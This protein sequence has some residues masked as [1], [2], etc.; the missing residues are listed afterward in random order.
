M[1]DFLH[2][3]DF[4]YTLY[5][6]FELIKIWSPRGDSLCSRKPCFKVNPS[7]YH[8]FKFGVDE[9][10]DEDS[11]DNFN[12]VNWLKARPI[13]PTLSIFELVKK[14]IILTARPQCV[15]KSIRQKLHGDY[16]IHGLSDGNPI[17]KIDFL[18]KL[19]S[20]NIII[21]EDSQS[22]IDLCNKNS[23]NNAKVNKNKNQTTI[24]YT[25]NE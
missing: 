5:E 1:N 21:Y 14:K 12:K 17:L 8:H 18:K 19:N 24:K 16:E 15:E 6:T 13:L 9:Y 4:D 22:V 20:K 3:F 11:F 25:F 2:I 23:I 10:V 7:E